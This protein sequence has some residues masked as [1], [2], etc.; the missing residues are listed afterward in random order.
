[1]I[2]LITPSG[3]RPAQINFCAYFMSRQTY[4]GKVVWIIVDDCIPHTTDLIHDDRPNWTIIKVYPS[5]PWQQGQNSQARNISAGINT[6]LANYRKEDIEGI[7]II[8][9]DD[10]YK[11]YY[12]EKMAPR[13][14]GFQATGERHTIYYNVFYQTY[15]TNPNTGHSSLFQ[16]AFSMDALPIFEGCFREKFIDMIFWS[17]LTKVNLFNDGNLSIGIKGMPGRYGIGAGHTKLRNMPRDNNWQYLSFL[18]GEDANLYSR[19]F[20]GGAQSS[21]LFANR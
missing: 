19:Y 21:R 17:R 20:G 18:I 6:L 4:T 7:F 13:L 8:E 3:G 5:P 2:A 16:T 9:D 1:M 11:P 14:T 12:L 15:F 10:Y